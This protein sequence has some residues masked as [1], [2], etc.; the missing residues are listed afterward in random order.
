MARDPMDS[1]PAPSWAVPRFSFSTDAIPERDRNA[2][3]RERLTA[4]LD[5]DVELLEGPPPR[6][7]MK[8]IKAGPV[9]LSDIEVSPTA[10]RR[11]RHHVYQNDD[12][13][14]FNP[15]TSGWQ[16]YDSDQ[17]NLRLETGQGCLL[18]AGGTGSCYL[19]TGG[20]AVGIRIEGAALRALVKH[21]EDVLGRP[22]GPDDPG[23]ALLMGYLRS[24]SVVKDTLTPQ[25]LH[26]FG[27]HIVDLVAAILGATRDG[28]AQAEAGGIRAARLRH[29][30][31][32]I[33]DR[34]CDPQF[35][36]E[37]VAAELK[38]SSRT[39][40]LI[41][42][43]TGSTFSEH[44]SEHRLHRAWRLLSDPQSHLSIAQIAFEAGFNDLSYFYRTFR[45]RFGETPASARAS[46]VQP[47]TA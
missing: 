4:L 28:M 23:M 38:V 43:E 34:A 36:I 8:L 16:Q 10:F 20:S 47:H 27:V 12:F 35:A 45:R 19:P 7:T 44:V 15:M 25:L 3:F 30:L 26:S 41:L 46:S 2:F 9:A 17:C 37:R 6:H 11:T 24:F 1:A 32:L 14:I 18:H 5:F 22:V 42:E 21:P 29:V 31:G 33:A 39:I 13:F 40:Q